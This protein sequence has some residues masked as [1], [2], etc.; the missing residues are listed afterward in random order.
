VMVCAIKC[1]TAMRRS[2]GCAINVQKDNIGRPVSLETYE[3]NWCATTEGPG[4]P[5]PTKTVA[6]V[7]SNLKYSVSKAMA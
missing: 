2:K 3:S 6:R 7:L 5:S 1:A 4:R